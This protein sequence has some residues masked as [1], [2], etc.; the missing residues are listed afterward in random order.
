MLDPDRS[1]VDAIAGVFES[2]RHLG[3]VAAVVRWMHREQLRF[4]SRPYLANHPAGGGVRWS[5]PTTSQIST[6][7]ENPRYAGA[8]VYGQTRIEHQPDG[9]TRSRK[10]EP[11]EWQV[12]IQNAHVGYIEWDEYLHSRHARTFPM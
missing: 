6:L 8:Y 3:S 9:T 4:P 11:D 5:L 1:I 12:C 2:Y 10:L 7:L